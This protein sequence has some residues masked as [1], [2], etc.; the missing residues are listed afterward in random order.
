MQSDPKHFRNALGAF[1]TGVTVVTTRDAHGNDVGMTANSFNSVSLNPP[2][3]LW[4]LAKSS[5]NIQAFADARSFAVHVLAR[6]QEAVSTRFATKGTD[7]FA[8][9]A[10]ERGDDGIP[11]L[12]DCTARFECRT[13]FQH[14]GGDHVIFV[15]E[16]AHFTHSERPPLVFHGGR[17]AG[18]IK[19]ATDDR[20][21]ES[22]MVSASLSPGDLLYHVARAYHHLR[23]DS[24][25]ERRRRN[26]SE[27]EYFTV[28]MLSME[29]DLPFS[30]LDS[31]VR[32]RGYQ[33]D[34]DV[35]DAL[36]AQGLV[37]AAEPVVHETVLGLTDA[38]RQAFIEV[39]AIA[40]AAEADALDGFQQDEVQL[41]KELLGRL[42][43][44]T[45][46]NEASGPAGDR[47]PSVV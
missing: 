27:A 5:S 46:R 43:P 38:G 41:L 39:I 3:V 14:E 4:S 25:L 21:A 35:I 29:G 15:G 32:H 6:D 10:L 9:L 22:D 28:A 8:G 42:I 26:W 17:Y 12:P 45:D 34:A 11:L 24:V 2:M 36:R 33:V 7:R 19:R 40:K 37:H 20:S 13:A 30:T 18:V 44:K 31:L 47:A 23:R 16:V 1:A